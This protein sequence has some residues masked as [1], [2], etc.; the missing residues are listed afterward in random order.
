[1]DDIALVGAGYAGLVLAWKLAESGARVTVYEE[2]DEG[3]VGLPR[4]C[5]GLVSARVVEGLDAW[6]LVLD[7]YKTVEFAARGETVALR[8]RGGVYRLDRVMLER[9]LYE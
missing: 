9:T 3:W 4:H 6:R 5:T 7:K 8:P 2:H 1:M